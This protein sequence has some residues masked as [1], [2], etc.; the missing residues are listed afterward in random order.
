MREQGIGFVDSCLKIQL[1]LGELKTL[2][3]FP[4]MV[5]HLDQCKSED[6]ASLVS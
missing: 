4:F 6:F 2:S 3:L 5:F 1:I